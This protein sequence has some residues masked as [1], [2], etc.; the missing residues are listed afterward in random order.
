MGLGLSH[1]STVEMASNLEEAL[2]TDQ[3]SRARRSNFFLWLFCWES[4]ALGDPTWL[5][6]EEKGKGGEKCS[7]S[8]HLLVDQCLIPW[9]EWSLGE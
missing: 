8:D 9:G 2:R 1:N 6:L 3:H 7:L 4:D 5:D